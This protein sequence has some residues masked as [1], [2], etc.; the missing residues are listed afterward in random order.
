MCRICT[1]T[2]VATFFSAMIL[3]CNGAAELE[4]LDTGDVHKVFTL[5]ESVAPKTTAHNSSKTKITHNSNK[6]KIEE[7]GAA[8]CPTVD[9]AYLKFKGDMRQI[10]DQVAEAQKRAKDAETKAQLESEAASRCLS[11]QKLLKGPEENQQEEMQKEIQRQVSKVKAH[12]EI[13]LQKLSTQWEAKLDRALQA[14]KD[15]QGKRMENQLRLVRLNSATALERWKQKARNMEADM[16]AMKA[17]HSL[18]VTRLK[19]QLKE[20]TGQTESSLAAAQRTRE[21]DAGAATLLRKTNQRNVEALHLVKAQLQAKMKEAASCAKACSKPKTTFVDDPDQPCPERMTHLLDQV[22]EI[23]GSNKQFEAKAL[24]N[25]QRLV[26]AR[27]KLKASREQ[28]AILQRE[29]EQ[30]RSN[31]V[32][33]QTQSTLASANIVQQPKD[34]KQSAVSAA[35]Q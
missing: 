8:G 17:S 7:D 31:K 15:K 33:S 10:Q 25:D 1:L 27:V 13:E 22:Q 14:D 2:W 26:R 16:T 11:A 4:M 5:V 34:A 12:Q 18:A 24:L 32:P 9:E 29:L 20:R 21:A 6:T 35:P 28:V 23:K 19:N 30:Y 3:V